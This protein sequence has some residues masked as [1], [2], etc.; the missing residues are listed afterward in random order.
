VTQDKFE[1]LK[2]AEIRDKSDHELAKLSSDLEAEFFSLRFRSGSGQLKQTANIKKA[3][4]NLA[5]IKTIQR[6]RAM[7]S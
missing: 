5:R 6:E 7:K 2:A 3:R 4:R 1:S